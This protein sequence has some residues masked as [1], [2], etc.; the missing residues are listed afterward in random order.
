MAAGVT[1]WMPPA[2]SRGSITVE[3]GEESRVLEGLSEVTE[4]E[5]DSEPE[6]EGLSEPDAEDEASASG[7]GEEEV[8]RA[9]GEGE[10]VSDGR[11]ADDR[12]GGVVEVGSPC[13]LTMSAGLGTGSGHGQAVVS[14][15]RR[16]RL[17]MRQRRRVESM[18]RD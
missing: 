8:G 15:E 18:L 1:I 14:V 2:G 7:D 10:L 5:S 17:E 12:E 9:V 13:R 3:S 6:E 11:A 16:M 4:S